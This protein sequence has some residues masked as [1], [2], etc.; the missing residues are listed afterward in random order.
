[1]MPIKADQIASSSDG[2]GKLVVASGFIWFFR[3][4]KVSFD[5]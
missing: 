4:S 3:F 5:F 1:M 2:F